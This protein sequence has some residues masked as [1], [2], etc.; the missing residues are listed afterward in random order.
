M[1]NAW[2]IKPL[3]P[4]G[5]TG[6]TAAAVGSPANT[7]NDFAG[8]IWTSTAQTYPTAIELRF[9]LGSDQPID[10]IA[11]FGVKTAP[12]DAKMRVLLATEAQGN[13]TG[14]YWMSDE[15]DL[16]AGSAMP[17]NGQG[18]ALWSAAPSAGGTPPAAARYV[19]I[20]FYKGAATISATV[21]RLVIGKRIELERN[22]AFGAGFG[23]KDLGSL[24]FSARAVLMRRRAKKLRTVSLTFS[25][26]H[27]D[28]VE[29]L[30]K[31]LLEQIGNTEMVAVITDPIADAQRQN[32]CYF[33]PL[34]GDLGHTW[35]KADAFEA[36]ANVVSIF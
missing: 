23:V 27:K 8:V 15:Q 30:T 18:T 19:D 3:T 36:K 14:P 20:Y 17:A 29:S 7:A 31:P 28:E 22:F 1:A 32:R 2:I 5:F 35:R 24:D 4:I 25:N 26:I 9:D 6:S 11:L 34:V 10:T 13:F 12:A 16:Y 33:G 21:S